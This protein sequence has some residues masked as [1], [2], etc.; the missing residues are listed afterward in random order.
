MWKFFKRRRVIKDCDSSAGDADNSDEIRDE[1]SQ[2]SDKYYY[3]NTKT[4]RSKQ[5]MKATYQWALHGLMTLVVLFVMTPCVWQT[6]YECSKYSSHIEK[7]LKY[8]SH[9]HDE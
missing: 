4:D 9:P 3:T 1:G 6:A 8:K 7:T 5:A 2:A